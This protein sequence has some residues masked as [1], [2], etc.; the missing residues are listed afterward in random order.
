MFYFTD[1]L[2]LAS[3]CGVQG[4]LALGTT[5]SLMGKPTPP[6]ALEL[7]VPF[8]IWEGKSSLGMVGPGHRD[9][10]VALGIYLKNVGS[11][12]KELPLPL[13]SVMSLVLVPRK[14]LDLIIHT[15]SPWIRG[16]PLLVQ[17]VV[18]AFSFNT[19]LLIQGC[20]L[21]AAH[22]LIT[23]CAASLRKPRGIHTLST[24]CVFSFPVGK[25][26]FK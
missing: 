14:L 13:N 25:R 16:G 10:L 26:H 7:E 19:G 24:L 11:D 12:L 4:H 6:R 5:S 2:E 23:V 3:V 8:F 1:S 15:H 18:T 22:P 9:S 21:R 20:L 17:Q